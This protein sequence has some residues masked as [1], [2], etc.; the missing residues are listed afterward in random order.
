MGGKARKY[1]KVEKI[2]EL[3]KCREVTAL[4]AEGCD[5]AIKIIELVKK[6][7]WEVIDEMKKKFEEKRQKRLKNLEKKQKLEKENPF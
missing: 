5:E 3:N 4:V 1:W 2:H 6:N 7:R